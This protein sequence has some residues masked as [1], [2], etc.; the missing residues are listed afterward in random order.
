M[1]KAVETKSE[2]KRSWKSIDV[3]GVGRTILRPSLFKHHPIS[4]VEEDAKGGFRFLDKPP[5]KRTIT[6]D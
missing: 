6:A 5:K 1:M 4:Y 2:A 3:S